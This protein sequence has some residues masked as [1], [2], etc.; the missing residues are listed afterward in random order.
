MSSD[1]LRIV[2]AADAGFQGQPSAGSLTVVPLEVVSDRKS[3]S[4]D[5]QFVGLYGGLVLETRQERRRRSLMRT[6]K[7]PTGRGSRWLDCSR[8]RNLLPSAVARP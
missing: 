7:S 6:P 5:M 2:F 4:T 3:R 1:M 8:N